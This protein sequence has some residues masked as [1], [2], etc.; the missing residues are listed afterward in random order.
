M[1]DPDHGNDAVPT[2]DADGPGTGQSVQE[3]ETVSPERLNPSGGMH[4]PS[5]MHDLGWARPPHPEIPGVAPAAQIDQGRFTMAVA[6]AAQALGVSCSTLRRW[7]DNGRLTAVRTTGGHR[8][9][10]ADDVW[11]LKRETDS[12]KPPLLRGARLPDSPITSLVPLLTDEGRALLRRAVFLLYVPGREG[13][14]GTVA[15]AT[16][17]DTWLAALRLAAAGA[18]TWDTV[19]DATDVLASDA[20]RGGAALSEGLVLF[21]LMGDL[22]QHRLHEVGAP[23]DSRSGARRLLRAVAREMMET[24]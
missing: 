19:I 21:E 1:I 11:R 24:R 17:L 18:A 12:S 2:R 9:F 8:R 3:R 6:D 14:F 20:R 23:M 10:F 4:S 15:G 13:W 7:S 5:T 16:R 22:I